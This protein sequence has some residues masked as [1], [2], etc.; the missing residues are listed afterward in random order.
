MLA[1]WARGDVKAIGKS[2]NEDL[3]E[4]PALQ[5]ALLKRR[6][7]SWS[8]WIERRMA[9]PGTIMVAVGAGH[10]AGDSSVQNLL[11]KQGY[12]VRRVQ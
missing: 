8:R 7:A 9:Q 10:L 6:N 4:S 1:A 5:E 2:F 12:R 3:A 11:E